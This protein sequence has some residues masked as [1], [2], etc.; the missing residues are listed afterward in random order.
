MKSIL[1]KGNF[2]ETLRIFSQTYQAAKNPLELLAA[3][4]GRTV[5]FGS[6]APCW[7]PALHGAGPSVGIPLVDC[8]VPD[9][10]D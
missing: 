6:T 1:E 4:P 3:H 10:I 7:T 9:Y 5:L 8:D 2:L